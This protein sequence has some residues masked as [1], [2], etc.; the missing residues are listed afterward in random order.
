MKDRSQ[1]K[2][3]FI[4]FFKIGAFTFG[5]GYAMVSLIQRE[6]VETHGWITNEDILDMLAISESTPGPIAINSATFVGYKVAGVLGSLCATIGVVLP[7]FVIISIL[8]L[9]IMQYKQI[10]WLTWMFEGIRAGVVALV[11]GAVIKLGKPVP[12]TIFTVAVMLATFLLASI[13]GV[14]VIFLLLAAAVLG[15]IRQA[16]TAKNASKKEGQS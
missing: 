14:D 12:K 6:V 2:K 16:V 7:S 5:G 1:C 4:T 10:K 9:F 13:L 11:I 8:S 15:I 3:L